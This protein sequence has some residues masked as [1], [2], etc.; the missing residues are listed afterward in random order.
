MPLLYAFYCIGISA[1]NFKYYEIGQI[2]QERGG[3]VFTG[4]AAGALAPRTPLKKP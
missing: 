4:G 1:G 2:I 3:K